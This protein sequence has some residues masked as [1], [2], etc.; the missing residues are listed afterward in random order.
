MVGDCLHHRQ[1][2]HML[3]VLTN[4][5]HFALHLSHPLLYI[6]EDH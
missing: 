5:F 3:N 2:L 6:I 4:L 1:S